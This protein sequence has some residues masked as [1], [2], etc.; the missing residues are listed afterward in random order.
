VIGTSKPAREKANNVLMGII[1]LIYA[2]R[3]YNIGNLWLDMQIAFVNDAE[4]T[5]STLNALSV[6]TVPDLVAIVFT[7]LSTWLADSI[8][9]KRAFQL[10]PT[11]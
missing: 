7:C 10:G 5:D 11:H 8:L 1:F 4:T 2:M 6:N 9:V 3:V